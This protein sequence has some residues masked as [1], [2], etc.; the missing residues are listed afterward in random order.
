MVSRYLA[1]HQMNSSLW[2]RQPREL[3]SWFFPS[4]CKTLRVCSITQ[5]VSNSLQPYDYSPPGSYSP[6]KN[7]GLGSHGLLQGLFQNPQWNPCLLS[8]SCIGSWEA[9]LQDFIYCKNE[10]TSKLSLKQC[11]ILGLTWSSSFVVIW[12][13]NW[14]LNPGKTSAHQMTYMPFNFQFISILQSFPIV[15]FWGTDQLMP[16][17]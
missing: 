7:T 16:L 9:Q 15:S 8:V 10:L 14:V 2:Q 4:S 11:R 12:N 3:I 13:P 17:V 1:E 5:V 6:C